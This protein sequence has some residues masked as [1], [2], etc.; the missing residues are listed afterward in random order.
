MLREWEKSLPVSL[1]EEIL[2]KIDNLKLEDHQTKKPYK[3]IHYGLVA[4]CITL[5]FC[6]N[7]QHFAEADQNLTL[8]NPSFTF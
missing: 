2:P 6:E 1:M 4:C 8:C 3:K 5:A 7:V